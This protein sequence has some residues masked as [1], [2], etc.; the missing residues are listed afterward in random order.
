MLI[1]PCISLPDGATIETVYS[2][3]RSLESFVTVTSTPFSNTVVVEF[4]G[5]IS[6]GIV[7][8]SAVPSL[9]K[10]TNLFNNLEF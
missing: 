4:S 7:T 6:A 10:I 9:K 3:R 2:G 1:F 8:L 5:P